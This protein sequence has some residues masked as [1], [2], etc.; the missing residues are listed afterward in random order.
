[1]PMLSK[2]T[3]KSMKP[4]HPRASF[5]KNPFLVT[6][7]LLIVCPL[8]HAQTWGG[9]GALSGNTNDAAHQWNLDANWTSAPFPNAVGVSA[10]VTADFTAAT[11]I[12]LQQ[13][14]TLGSLS[15][16]DTG[17]TGDSVITLAPG[18][19]ATNKLIFDNTGS[20]NATLTTAGATN[21][22]SAPIL[23]SD[24]LDLIA[25]NGFSH[26]SGTAPITDGGL[27][28]TIRKTGPGTV[29]LGGDN[30]FSGGIIWGD[31]SLQM[32][33]FG[34]PLRKVLGTGTFTFNNLVG[35]IGNTLANNADVSRTFNQAFVQ[36]NAAVVTGTQY[37]SISYFGGVT[38]YRTMTFNGAFSTGPNYAETQAILLGANSGTNGLNEGSL[39]FN[40]DWSNYNAGSN[41]LALRIAG[42]SVVLGANPVPDPGNPAEGFVSIAASGGYSISGNDVTAS[43]KLIL[44]APN[45]MANAVDFGGSGFGM[46]NSFGARNAASTTALQT[47]DI[48]L[49]DADGANVFSQNTNAVLEISS[50]IKGANALRIND[51]YSFTSA[52]TVHSLQ[53]PT[54]TVSLTRAAGSGTGGIPHT[55]PVTV[56]GGTLLVSNTANSATGAG[57]VTV[58]LVGAA[59]S[60]GGGSSINT[61]ATALN[62]RVITGV[63]TAIAQTLR[64]GQTITGTNLP[65]GS[66]VITGITLGN[67]ASVVAPLPPNNSTIVIDKTIVVPATSTVSFTDLAT[68]FSPTTA[69]LGGT[70]RISPMGANGLLVNTGSSLGF[71]DGATDDFIVA[72]RQIPA[73]VDPPAAAVPASG[74]ATFGSGATFAMEL[75]APGTSDVVAF[76]G[77]GAP[78]TASV[79]FNGNVVNFTNLG[80]LAPGLYTLFTFDSDSKYTGTLSKGTGLE[81]YPTSQ[82]IYNTNN[83]QLEVIAGGE[84]YASWLATKFSPAELLNPTI[85]GP[86]ADP[87][88]DGMGN[89]LEYVV[90]TEPKTPEQGKGPSLSTPANKPTVTLVAKTSSLPQASVKG[91]SST[92]LIDW[93][94]VMPLLSSTPDSPAVGQTTLVFQSTTTFT[95][96]PK[97]FYRLELL[98][99]PAP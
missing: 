7:P 69:T 25:T 87:D 44:G 24:H 62:T 92:T 5:A 15:L 27:G 23:L 96:D 11:S 95:G 70:G 61:G 8:A 1:M 42:G 3:H 84:T 59:S 89:L 57:Q 2:S 78:S 80:G 97:R 19:V 28:K 98:A 49:S 71:V 14:I 79:V 64:I 48:S 29:S 35:G 20:A 77:L 66:A 72:F 26:G 21:A 99:P 86:G 43:T 82:F 13:D 22:I 17:A 58:G 32:G 73:V 52:D 51:S 55:G 46:R 74:T 88:A 36:N 94:T 60:G 40:G 4:A 83:I 85:S 81:A 18:T 65:G 6:L 12:F 67:P 53:T 39:F 37:A 30:T 68:S 54:G 16:N 9:S 93:P 91:Q 10:S 33:G 34:A 76:T 63:N 50:A 31:G 41:G 75:N 47:S 45:F 56:A 38:G 90:G